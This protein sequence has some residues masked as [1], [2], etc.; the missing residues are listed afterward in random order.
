MTDHVTPQTAIRLKQAG[1]KQPEQKPGQ[2]WFRENRLYIIISIL[3]DTVGKT[4]MLYEVC[5]EN[6]NPDPLPVRLLFS[7]AF[8]YA[9]GVGKILRELGHDFYVCWHEYRYVCRKAY[10]QK[11]VT[12]SLV[13]KGANENVAEACALTYI[14]N[15]K[16]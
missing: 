2:F 14:E 7:D 12:F 5:E 15:K 13:A 3:T 6:R 16:P 10:E 1:F 8:I 11:N 4:A 9:P